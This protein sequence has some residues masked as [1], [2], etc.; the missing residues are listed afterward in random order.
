MT[1][2]IPINYKLHIEPD[3]ENFRFSGSTEILV[4]TSKPV[5]EVSLN[6]LELDIRN[7][8]VLAGD[9]SPEC[10]FHDILIRF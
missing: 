2:I 6:I 4:D 1:D 3:L 7:C 10:T 9:E 8:K 5:T